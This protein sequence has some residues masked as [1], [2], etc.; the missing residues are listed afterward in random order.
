[1]KKIVLLLLVVP[2]LFGCTGGYKCEEYPQFMSDYLPYY[3]G[4]VVSFEN[5]QEDI[6]EFEV[7]SSH[8]SQEDKIPINCKC[9]CDGTKEVWLRNLNT[10]DSIVKIMMRFNTYIKKR[11]I[12]EALSLRCSVGNY[13]VLNDTL[14]Y[15]ERCNSYSQFFYSRSDFDPYKEKNSDKVPLVLELTND[16]NKVSR[17]KIERGKGVVEFDDKMNNCTWKLVK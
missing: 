12:G 7:I 3:E 10:N 1:M 17:V 6:M 4:Q 14:G 2:F 13:K 5:G 16:N 11:D 8:I 9:T 15:D